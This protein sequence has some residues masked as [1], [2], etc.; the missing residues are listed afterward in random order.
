MQIAFIWVEF[1][2]EGHRLQSIWKYWLYGNNKKSLLFIWCYIFTKYVYY[3][4]LKMGS[5]AENQQMQQVQLTAVGRSQEAKMR[6]QFR[7]ITVHVGVYTR[8]H[9][10]LLLDFRILL[11]SIRMVPFIY[12]YIRCSFLDL[13]LVV[14][15]LVGECQYHGRQPEFYTNLLYN[16]VTH[17]KHRL[18]VIAS[19]IVYTQNKDLS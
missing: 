14:I 4:V 11:L 10:K 1:F 18:Q 5:R 7:F 9:A 17:R 2:I 12:G 6:T 15:G 19:I 13:S 16:V 8:R 3:Y